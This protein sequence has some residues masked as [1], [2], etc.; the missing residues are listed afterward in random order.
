MSQP[1]DHYERV[2]NFTDHSVMQ[3]SVPHPGQKIDQELNA[4]REAI[5]DAIDRLGEIQRDD[6]KIRTEALDNTQFESIV[7]GA[8]QTAQAAAAASANSASQA[9]SSATAAATSATNAQASATSAAGFNT[10]AHTHSQ[11]ALNSKLAAENS[12]IQA[13]NSAQSFGLGVGTV[14]TGNAGSNASVSVN[15]TGPSYTINFTIPRG[16]VGETGATGP[17]GPQGPTG[18][19]GA[20]GPQG[21][22]GDK[23]DTGDT[24][25]QGPIGLTGP[26]GATGATGPQGPQGPQGATGLQ[27]PIGLTGPQGPAGPTG[28]TGPQG[29]A[30]QGVPTGGTVGMV[31]KKN[32]SANYDASWQAESGGAP[33]NSP[34]FTG[35]VSVTTNSTLP[36]M[37][38]TQSGTGAVL[39]LEDQTGDTSTTVIDQYGKVSTI[40]PTTGNAGFNLP[41]GTAPNSPVNGD[42]WSTTFGLFARISNATQQLASQAWVGSNY[43]LASVAYPVIYNSQAYFSGDFTVQ[44]SWNGYFLTVDQTG[45]SWV[46]ATMTS[47]PSGSRLIFRQA[48]ADPIVFNGASAF[49]NK[50]ASA[51]PNAIVHAFY[52]GSNWCLQGDLTYVPAGYVYSSSCVYSDGYDAAGTFWTGNWV[53]QAVVADGSGGTTTSNNPNSNGCWY[54]NGYVISLSSQYNQQTVSWMVSDSSYNTVAYGDS[55]YSYQYD[56]EVADGSGG[57]SYNSGL[58]WQAPYGYIF[59]SGQYYDSNY[60]SYYNYEVYSDGWSGY[61]INQYPA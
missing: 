21:L 40:A 39:V 28:S 55:T 58:T 57:S 46:T 30:G 50:L 53:S 36:A 5:N 54:P 1:P 37:K 6:G 41:H 24:G 47:M 7:N 17:Q 31:L 42:V 44:Y 15:G 38:I 29:P 60:G 22:K 56:A 4:A 18:A 51:G 26:A 34:A 45:G 19:T 9:Y 14:T 16:N 2:F 20:Q 23:G 35:N 32:S 59:S 48:G 61:Y 12:A 27:G 43:V 11:S 49:Q 52:N 10:L 33:L 25:P 8:T 13:A 3:P